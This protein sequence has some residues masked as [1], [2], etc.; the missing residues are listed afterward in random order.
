MGSIDSLE[1]KSL[2]GEVL[3]GGKVAFLQRREK[4]GY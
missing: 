4:Y 1:V 2:V 3:E